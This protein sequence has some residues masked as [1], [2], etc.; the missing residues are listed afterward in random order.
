MGKGGRGR[1]GSGGTT[2]VRIGVPLD[3]IGIVS[4]EARTSIS[5]C[6]PGPG[7]SCVCGS[8]TTATA[9]IGGV[10]LDKLVEQTIVSKPV[11]QLTADYLYVRSTLLDAGATLNMEFG[12]IALS[13]VN[14]AY[15]HEHITK[16]RA[17][18]IRQHNNPPII[19]K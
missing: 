14:D 6:S 9:T 1:G 4:M 5:G 8:T 19:G 7:W 18:R 3:G 16:D 12:D 13:I 17:R 11:I 15:N 2:K 10:D